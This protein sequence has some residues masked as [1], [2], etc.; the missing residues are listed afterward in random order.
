MQTVPGR[1]AEESAC[2]QRAKR[3]RMTDVI[4]YIVKPSCTA[5]CAESPSFASQSWSPARVGN[6]VDPGTCR[7]K[8]EFSH[9]CRCS[10]LQRGANGG[11][12]AAHTDEAVRFY[13]KCGRRTV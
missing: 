1:A 10:I 5:R 2:A 8:V 13:V 12:R 3:T 4:E 6:S 11:S 9:S 7:R